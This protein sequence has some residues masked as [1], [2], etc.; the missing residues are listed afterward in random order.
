[1]LPA[2]FLAFTFRDDVIALAAKVL[3]CYQLQRSLALTK[4]KVDPK[5]II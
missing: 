2:L 4:M 5:S 1:M 3:Y